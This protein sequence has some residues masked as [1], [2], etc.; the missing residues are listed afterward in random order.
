M[1]FNSPN[2]VFRTHVAS[3][4]GSEVWIAILAMV[5]NV[6]EVILTS[7]PPF[8]KIAKD[9]MDGKFK[10]V[11]GMWCSLLLS[12]LANSTYPR[13]LVDLRLR[14]AAHNNAG[15]WHSTSLSFISHSYPDF[16]HYRTKQLSAHRQRLP[17]GVSPHLFHPRQIPLPPPT[18]YQ[19]F[20]PKSANA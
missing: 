9:Y 1:K 7:L 8:W 19:R 5:K 18:T 17:Q 2:A 12:I 20:Y 16:L 13:A 10:K 3:G 11:T 4:A 6:S 15:Q 14:G